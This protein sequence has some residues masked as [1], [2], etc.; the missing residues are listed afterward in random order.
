VTAT[1]QQQPAMVS[2]NV[3]RM[4]PGTLNAAINGQPVSCMGATCTITGPAGASVRLTA[5]PAAGAALANWSGACS[6]SAPSCT[7]TLRA[8]GLALATFRANAQDLA[9]AR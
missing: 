9:S 6:G 3:M 2:M 7:I 5:T 4:G 8:G 1:F